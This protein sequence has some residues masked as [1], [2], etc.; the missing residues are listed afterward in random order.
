VDDRPRLRGG[1]STLPDPVIDL[2]R[3]RPDFKIKLLDRR[4]PDRVAPARERP[5]DGLRAN[6]VGA[7]Y[8]DCADSEGPLVESGF[9]HEGHHG[10]DAV[11]AAEVVVEPEFVDEAVAVLLQ[12]L[13]TFAAAA[14]DLW[15]RMGML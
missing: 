2:I 5:D 8:E 9:F 12:E 11:V 3:M 14:R 4:P 6:G 7:V 13:D 10:Q 15:I 1:W